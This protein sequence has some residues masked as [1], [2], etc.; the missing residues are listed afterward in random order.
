MRQ[1]SLEVG[2]F[3]FEPDSPN[4]AALTYNYG[5]VAGGNEGKSSLKTALVLYEAIHGK[6][7]PEVIDLL[8]DLG[9][10]QQSF[11]YCKRKFWKG[12]Y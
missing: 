10:S 2:K 3:L 4:I 1:T 8:I 9:R 11:D 7:S 6:D 5:K 12:V